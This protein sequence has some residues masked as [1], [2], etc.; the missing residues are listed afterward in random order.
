MT[1]DTSTMVRKRRPDQREHD[2]RA[3]ELYQQL[4]TWSAVA[5]ELGY[6][7]GSVARRAGYR[8]ARATGQIVD[9]PDSPTV[10]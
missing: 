8:Y 2:K 6:A 1:P 3:W 4:G 10:D 9:L 5:Q 7:N